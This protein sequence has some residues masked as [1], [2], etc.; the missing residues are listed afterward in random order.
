MTKKF[1]FDGF[2]IND[3]DEYASRLATLT[4]RGHTKSEEIAELVL[5]PLKVRRAVLVYQG[6]IAN[7][8]EVD[9]FNVK[10]FG[11]EAKRL[12]QNDFRSCETFAYG[13]AVAGVMVATMACNMAGDIIK[14]DWSE[15]LDEQP[16]SKNFR[17]VFA[18]VLPEVDFN[19]TILKVW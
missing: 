6:G 16:F 15:S 1:K 17:P 19:G 3:N 13:L 11:R 10:A 12:M 5:Q 9:C 8:F 7:V 18:G 14:Q 2:G 4:E